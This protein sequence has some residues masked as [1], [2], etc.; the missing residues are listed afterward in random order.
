MKNLLFLCICLLCSSCATEPVSTAT[1]SKHTLPA[2]ETPPLVQENIYIGMPRAEAERI[3]GSPTSV[4]DMAT[5]TTAVWVFSPG[6][7]K[8]EPP[9]EPQSEVFNIIKIIAVTGA[10]IVSPIA[11]M[12][13]NIGSQ[14]YNV[15][16]SKDDKTTPP[17]QTEADKTRIVT[18]EFRDSKVF[19]IQ[20]A[21]ATVIP[22]PPSQ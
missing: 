9:P 11:G 2:K 3:L 4:T 22:N 21:R 16:S 7:S 1:S 20:R 13:T 12:V 19:S 15:M 14:V 5:G 6:A 8:A 17:A 10:G 18:I